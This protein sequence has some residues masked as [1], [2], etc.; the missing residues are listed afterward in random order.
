VADWLRANAPLFSQITIVEAAA[1]ASQEL[2]VEVTPI[3]VRNILKD[4]GLASRFRIS[5]GEGRTAGEGV[6]A[7]MNRLEVLVAALYEKLGEPLPE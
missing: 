3:H 1:K 4:L 6:K 7:R 2:A 5:R